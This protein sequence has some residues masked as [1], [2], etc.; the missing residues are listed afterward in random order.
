MQWNLTFYVS[1]IFRWGNLLCFV[2]VTIFNIFSTTKNTKKDWQLLYFNLIDMFRFILLL[3][4]ILLFL[5]NFLHFLWKEENRRV[6]CNR[7]VF[8]FKSYSYTSVYFHVGINKIWSIKKKILTD[9]TT[10]FKKKIF[11][12]WFFTQNRSGKKRGKN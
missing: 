5:N 3:V 2:F 8:Y 7:N 1:E 6:F 10:L 4:L 9:K 11:P 12:F